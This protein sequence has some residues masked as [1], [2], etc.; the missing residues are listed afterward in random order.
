MTRPRNDCHS[1]EF[2]LW[3]R[4]QPSLD[5][6]LEKYATTNLDYLWEHY[7]TGRWMLLEEKRYG[8]CLTWSQAKQFERIDGLC[9]STDRNYYGFHVIRFACTSP[10][11]GEVWIDGELSDAIGLTA[12]LRFELKRDCYRSYF[13]KR[14]EA[15]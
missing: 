6:K 4:E 10:D 14:A 9:A 13:K 11:D 5:S 1:T 8:A 7:A 12:F 2:G 3:L 15:A